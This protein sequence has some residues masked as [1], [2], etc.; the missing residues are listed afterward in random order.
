MTRAGTLSSRVGAVAV[1]LGLHAWSTPARAEATVSVHYESEDQLELARRIASELATEGFAVEIQSTFE[2]SVCDAGA[3]ELVNVPKEGKVW[4]RIASNPDDAELAVASICYLGAQPL[5]LRAAP[6]APRSDPGQLALATAE[7]LNGL[8]S[9]VAPETATGA[10][11]PPKP[12]HGTQDASPR[13]SP[14]ATGSRPRVPNSV[15]VAMTAVWTLPDLP[16]TL[17]ASARATL[18]VV[19]GIGI[20]LDALVPGGG[21]ELETDAT[22]ARVRTAWFRVGPRFGA[23]LDDFELSA[24]ALA[25][26]ALTWVTAV[27]SPP[28]IG[29][30]DLTPGAV[31]TLASTVEYPRRSPIFA[32]VSAAASALLPGVEVDLGDGARK[33]RGS[34]PVEASIGLGARWGAD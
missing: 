25:G 4:I 26:P 21:P 30:T 9:K 19:P 6:S 32:C 11:P 18:G 12:E 2:P 10:V 14:P 22:T 16:V 31:L 5:V 20:A 27:A 34:W 28:Q 13:P 29:A 1:S 17:A 7:A 3:T 23:A 33:P 8:R 24:A 15:A